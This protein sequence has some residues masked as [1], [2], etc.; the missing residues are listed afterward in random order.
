M[1]GA[2]DTLCGKMVVL[3]K[4]HSLGTQ[5]LLA[6]CTSLAIVLFLVVAVLPF[7]MPVLKGAFQQHALDTGVQKISTSIVYDDKGNPIKMIMPESLQWVPK[8]IPDEIKYAVVD[9]TGRVLL[10][11]DGILTPFAADNEAFEVKSRRFDSNYNGHLM[12]VVQEATLSPTNKEIYAQLAISDRFMN[13]LTQ[14]K[15]PFILPVLAIIVSLF[16]IIFAMRITLR[17]MLKPLHDVSLAALAIK[18]GN[19]RQRLPLESVPSE[20]IPLISSFNQVLDRLEKG[21]QVQ[22]ELLASTAHELKTPLMILRGQ[23]ETEE[24]LTS[25]TTLLQDID[26]ISRQIHQL[27]HLA[28]V[29]EEQNYKFAAT[30]VASV[31]FDVMEYLERFARKHDVFVEFDDASMTLDLQADRSAFFVLLKNLVEN[32]IVHSPAGST[33]TITLDEKELCVHDVGKGIPSEYL[34]NLFKRFWRGADRQ[35]SGAGLG[36]AICK[37]IATAHQ[38]TLHV[39]DT[40]PGACFVV[41]FADVRPC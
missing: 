10:G 13:I 39:R 29:S 9:R 41:S 25:R 20:L 38:W 8:A 34:P 36:L 24:T 5:L 11:S 40:T 14:G 31:I 18:P 17:R 37:E 30:N 19:V 3:M 35:H 2:L 16:V 21:Y 4:K 28:E 27:L 33:V 22:Q 6:F 7:G 32:A 12:H 1:L 15:F 23:I 26:F